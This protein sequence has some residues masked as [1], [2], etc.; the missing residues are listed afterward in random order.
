G[1][2]TGTGGFTRTGNYTQ[3]MSGC[4]NDYTGVTTIQG[5]LSVDCLADGGQASGIG[6]SSNASS[7]LVFNGGRLTYTG[8]SI[9]IDRGFTLTSNGYVNVASAA[10]VLEFEGVVAGGGQLRKEGDGVLVLSGT[11]TYTGDTV[12]SGGILRAGASDTLGTRGFILENAAGVALDLAGYDHTIG[13]LNGGGALGGNVTLGDATLTLNW[14]SGSA[15]FAGA[16]SG[17]GGLIKN[18]GLSQTL[19][20]CASDY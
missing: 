6:A 19:T 17:S 18:G 12:I 5:T 15:E 7:N 20:S 14:S 10:T 11:N 4:G 1:R 2:I 13:F 9:A 8:G 16:I 3:T